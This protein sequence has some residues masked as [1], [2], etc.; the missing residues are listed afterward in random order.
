[1]D[2]QDPPWLNAEEREAWLTLASVMV[3]LPGALDAQLQRDA[4]MTHFEFQVLAGL[5]ESEDRT[6][7]MSVLAQWAEGSLSRLSQVVSRL[8]KRGW[9]RR[10]PDPEDGRYTLATLTDAG[11][12][13][14]VAA[15]PLHVERVRELVF[16]S[17]T[18]AQVGQLTTIG[19]RIMGA[20]DRDGD[21]PGPSR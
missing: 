4:G 9:V 11:W 16:D 1:M 21:C 20:V 6:L 2:D 5:S 19:R 17:L 13:T 8:E 10:S 12:A 14:I 3:R 7:R 15:A 18:K